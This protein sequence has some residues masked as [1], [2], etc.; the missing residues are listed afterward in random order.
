MSRYVVIEAVMECAM[1]AYGHVVSSVPALRRNLSEL[2]GAEALRVRFR[3][4]FDGG[5]GGDL[6][7][8]ADIFAS[9]AV[10]RGPQVH[11]LRS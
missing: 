2:A 5:R 1:R 8:L 10:V 11:E 3:C 7:A 6:K 9:R 4:F